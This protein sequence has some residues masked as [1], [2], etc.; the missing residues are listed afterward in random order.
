MFKP[1]LFLLAAA[2]GTL[3]SLWLGVTVFFI[4]NMVI[5]GFCRDA[6]YCALHEPLSQLALILCA[7]SPLL[8]IGL[9]GVLVMA[10]SHQPSARK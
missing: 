6:W 5:G 3:A 1:V 10:A 2:G 9:A 4:A 7:G 8:G